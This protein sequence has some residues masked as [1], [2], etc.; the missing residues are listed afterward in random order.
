ML[1]YS[2]EGEKGCPSGGEGFEKTQG[3]ILSHSLT[4]INQVFPSGRGVTINWPA[5]TGSEMKSCLGGTQL[6]RENSTTI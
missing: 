3:L 6:D 2:G 5:V 4:M 1:Y